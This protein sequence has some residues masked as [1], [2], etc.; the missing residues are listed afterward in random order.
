MMNF[1]FCPV[2]RLKIFIVDVTA[3]WLKLE[4]GDYFFRRNFC[5]LGVVP[6]EQQNPNLFFF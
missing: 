4:F 5:K 2:L 3:I 6:L 1:H